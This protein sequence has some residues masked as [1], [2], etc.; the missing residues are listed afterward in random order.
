M[1]IHEIAT[2]DQ[3]RFKKSKHYTGLTKAMNDID[4]VTGIQ[5]WEKLL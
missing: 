1:R 4:S 5:R 2:I 3:F